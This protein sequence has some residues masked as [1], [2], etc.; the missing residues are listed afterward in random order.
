MSE[1]KVEAI[2]GR[3]HMCGNRISQAHFSLERSRLEIL[4]LDGLSKTRVDKSELDKFQAEIIIN[5]NSL[6]ERI[7]VNLFNIFELKNE[8]DT[9][10]EKYPKLKAICD[11]LWQKAD[12]GKLI[13]IWRNNV[14]AHGKFMGKDPKVTFASDLGPVKENIEEIYIASSLIVS[15]IGI[16]F[17]NVSE[18]EATW[19]NLEAKSI[20][21]NESKNDQITYEVYYKSRKKAEAIFEPIREKLEKENLKEK[22]DYS[23]IE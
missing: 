18:Y 22:I 21:A 4:A 1:N 3:L 11:E 20:Q 15:M 9:F 19:K 5:V 10:L 2:L 7:I 23:L 17:A 8:L 6:N 12:V 16:I 13:G 14:T